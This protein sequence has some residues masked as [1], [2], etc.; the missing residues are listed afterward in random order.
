MHMRTKIFL[1]L[2]LVLAFA[3]VKAQNPSG[4]PSPNAPGTYYNIGWMKEDSGHINANRQPNFVP[5]FPGTEV[6]YLNPGVDT[7]MW[8]WTGA[9]WIKEAKLGD[10]PN[11][12]GVSPIVVTGN[13]IS[14]P[15]CGS[16]SGGIT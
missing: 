16:G 6:F 13:V 3:G 1:W 5:K 10:I 2:L 9:I 8:L 4:L 14:C 11:L 12:V 15:T 7:S